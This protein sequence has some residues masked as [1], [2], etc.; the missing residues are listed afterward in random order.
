MMLEQILNDERERYIRALKQSCQEVKSEFP[1]TAFELLIDINNNAIPYPYRYF[2]VDI[3]SKTSAGEHKVR[4]VVMEPNDLIEPMNFVC[5]KLYLELRPFTWNS[6]QIL[7]NKQIQSPM[8]LE[9]WVTCWLDLD[10][11][12]E[13]DG[14]S[15]AI[16]S[17]SRV[18]H[19]QGWSYFTVDFGTAPV[20]AFLELI[21]WLQNEGIDRVVLKH[22]S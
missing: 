19:S 3:I 13:K 15:N 22:G 21:A 6:I 5:G 17:C 14:N 20:A 4:E 9:K 16:H 8:D 10:D 18:E 2:R 1:S 11:K 12:N 7:I